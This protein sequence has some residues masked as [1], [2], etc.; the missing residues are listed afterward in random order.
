MAL[1]TEDDDCSAAVVE[2][3]KT[4]SAPMEESEPVVRRLYASTECRR[5]SVIVMERTLGGLILI[6]SEREVLS[7]ATTTA[8]K[9]LSSR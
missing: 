3:T 8:L 4:E 5:E 2:A 1:P 6:C 9:F 7:D